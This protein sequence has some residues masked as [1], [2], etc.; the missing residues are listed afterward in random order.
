[1]EMKVTESKKLVEIWLTKAE[2]QDPA[3][4]ES[5][6]GLYAKYKAMGYLVVVF[7][8]GTEDLYQGILALLKSNLHQSIIREIELEKAAKAKQEELK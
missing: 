2:N 1:M 5:L 6:K 3:V 4:D 7:R 8:S